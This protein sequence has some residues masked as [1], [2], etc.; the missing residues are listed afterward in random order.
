MKKRGIV[1]LAICLSFLL[2]LMICLIQPVFVNYTTNTYYHFIYSI[3]KE[4]GNATINN[5][6]TQT[7][8]YNTSTERLTKI[9][10]LITQNFTDYWWP[11]Q[12]SDRFCYILNRDPAYNWCNPLYGT[13]FYEFSNKDPRYYI[14]LKDKLGNVTIQQTNDLSNNPEWIAYQK[15]GDCQAISVLFNETANRS[16]F[17]SRTVRFQGFDHMW[18]E[19][20]INGSWKV[21]DIQQFGQDN[22]TNI[23]DLTYWNAN[24]KI[25]AESYYNSPN[26]GVY[27]LNLTDDGF[28]ENLTQSYYPED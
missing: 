17:V 26:L 23:T 21:F 4:E 14:Y 20:N 12:R 7:Q 9:A 24:P 11:Y 8:N 10:F 2:L 15:A 6:V 18:N 1:K 5:M 3:K 27:T 25:F 22:G 19:V 16:G 13:P 28:G